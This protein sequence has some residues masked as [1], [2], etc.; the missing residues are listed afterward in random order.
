M[1]PEAV[2]LCANFG[3]IV[4]VAQGKS[5]EIR[6]YHMSD[7]LLQAELGK[8]SSGNNQHY[9]S[10][11]DQAVFEDSS[12]KDSAAYLV[13]MTKAYLKDGNVDHALKFFEAGI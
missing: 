12:S 4:K 9:Y 13:S 1:V 10:L 2:D 6:D 8:D 7:A 3:K 11:I 5:S